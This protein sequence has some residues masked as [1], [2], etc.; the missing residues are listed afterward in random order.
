LIERL[1]IHTGAAKKFAVG[2][3]RVIAVGYSA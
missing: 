2:S 1:L 3:E